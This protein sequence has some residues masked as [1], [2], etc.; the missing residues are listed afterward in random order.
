[1]LQNKQLLATIGVDKAENGPL[2]VWGIGH[3]ASHRV[4]RA[5]KGTGQVGGLLRAQ[6]ALQEALQARPWVEA[7]EAR[8]G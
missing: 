2:K 6:E 8:S 3:S 1:M 4:P 5:S 7:S